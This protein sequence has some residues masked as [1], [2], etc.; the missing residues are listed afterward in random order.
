[1]WPLCARMKIAF[2]PSVYEHAA[3]LI[4]ATPWE[5]SR[6]G[7]LIER[8]HRTAYQTYA[9]SPVVVGID[10]YNLEAEAYGCRVQEPGGNGI[11]AIVSGIFSS[12]E[13]TRRL[14]PFD[15]ATSGRVP[16]VID[17]A[18]RLARSLPQARVLVPLS[19]PFSI[20]AS[21]R[22]LSGL[23]EDLVCSPPAVRDFLLRLV[24]GQ[25]RFARAARQA[26]L[27]VAFFE[28]A[29]AP[30][31]LSPQQFGDVELP[32]LA[33]TMRRVSDA[34]GHPVPCIIGGDTEQILEHILGTG[35]S[36]VI[37]PA[38]TDQNAFMARLGQ[39]DDV[40]VRVNIDP[41][42]VARGPLSRICAEVD[43]IVHLARGRSNVLL[44]T[45][46]LPYETPPEHVLAI[47][48]YAEE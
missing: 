9:H 34:V 25:V 7:E 1:M 2:S 40:A 36:Y 39:R 4:G 11:P 26:G 30:P 19:G 32:A 14:R 37:C 24:E 6:S 33:A 28:S 8:A 15:P 31:L 29:A 47:K 38:E 27:D 12:I 13:E 23:L 17:A 18:G 21:L 42:T 10:I 45:G 20:A 46:A 43:R 16:M 48:R 41:L 44:G 3:L 5:V 22:G 35:T